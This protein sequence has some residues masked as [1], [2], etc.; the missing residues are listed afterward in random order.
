MPESLPKIDTIVVGA[1]GYVGGE[2]LR[3]LAAHPWLEMVG[4]LSRSRA[5]APIGQVRV[6]TPNSTPARLG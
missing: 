6:W 2:L 1:T 4:A 5:G 3:L